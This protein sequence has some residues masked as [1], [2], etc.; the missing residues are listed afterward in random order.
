MEIRSLEEKPSNPKS[1]YAIIGLYIFDEIVYE[2]LDQISPSKRRIR[3][4]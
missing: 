2:Y 4:N 1:N 3:N